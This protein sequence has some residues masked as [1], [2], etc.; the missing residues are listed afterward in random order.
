MAS[1]PVTRW[2]VWNPHK[3]DAYSGETEDAAWTAAYRAIQQSRGWVCSP[4]TAEVD[5]GR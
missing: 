4:V 2:I 3:P 5:N 1:K